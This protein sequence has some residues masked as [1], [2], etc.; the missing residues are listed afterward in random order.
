MFASAEASGLITTW[1]PGCDGP[2]LEVGHDDGDLD[3]FV[4]VEIEARHLA[5]DPHQT[6]VLGSPHHALHPIDARPD[7]PWA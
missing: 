5:V 4:D 1:K 7:S 3:E 2:Q 6:I